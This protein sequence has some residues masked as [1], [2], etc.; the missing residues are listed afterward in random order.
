V[1]SQI[2]RFFRHPS[3]ADW[4]KDFHLDSSGAPVVCDSGG[5]RYRVQRMRKVIAQGDTWRRCFDL[6][7]G[8]R[9]GCR[10][11]L[12]G[13]P[14]DAWHTVRASDSLERPRALSHGAQ[15]RRRP[16]GEPWIRRLS[17]SPAGDDCPSRSRTQHRPTQ[18]QAV[19][20]AHIAGTIDVIVRNTDSQS[21]TPKSSLT[22]SHTMLLCQRS[23]AFRPAL[24]RHTVEQQ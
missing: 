21:S 8:R 5:V 23:Q 12:R 7:S 14:L 17:G 15:N 2:S 9:A 10:K 22:Y 18:I 4:K 13:H 24:A 6:R 16:R 3:S 19:T 11:P 1:L 20:P